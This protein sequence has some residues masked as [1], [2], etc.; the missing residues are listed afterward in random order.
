MRFF[1]ICAMLCAAPAI[2]GPFSDDTG[3]FQEVRRI[4]PHVWVLAEPAF[5]AQ[6][7]GNVT[8]IEQSDGLVLVDAGGSAG[9]GRRIV[10]LVKGL[11]AKPVKVVI[12]S[13]WHGDK[14]QGLSEIL[15]AWPEA[16]TIST[17]ATQA[18]LSDP[19]TMNSP[20]APDAAKNAALLDSVRG[21]IA[22]FQTAAV[23]AKTPELRP[24]YA[25]AARMMAQYLHDADGTLTLSTKDGF[26]DNLILTDAQVPVDAMFLGRADTD[27]D[28]VVWLPRQRILVAGE[29]VILPFPYGFGA[30]PAD[31][32]AVLDKM[33]SFKFKT[34][35]PG[36]GPPQ[37]DLA[38]LDKIEAAL[39][40]VRAQVGALAA[41]G[42]SLE[43]VKAK[44][45]FR[46][47]IES[48]TH[49]D[50]WL[51]RWMR[52]FWIDPIV[53]SAYKEAK[54]QPISQNL[55]G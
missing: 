39:K 50:P 46:A 33:R 41:R 5:Q 47:Q 27:G 21:V 4:D 7:I 51:A 1:I 25:L 20:A 35:V 29:T 12:L 53:T 32:I 10:A 15:K 18:H 9:S 19:G 38:Q 34:L 23:K 30:Y 44:V 45:D 37:H 24:Q 11:S 16:R 31:W 43:D 48:F 8:V 55:K 54:G 42:L 17:K 52:D 13:Q 22:F 49:G 3:Y 36:H 2:A 28:A 6:P 26:D 40:D 14:V